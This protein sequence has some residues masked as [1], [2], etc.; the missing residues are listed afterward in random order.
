MITVARHNTFIFH[1]EIPANA[2]VY[3]ENGIV[4]YCT[5]FRHKRTLPLCVMVYDESLQKFTRRISRNK[6]F[7]DILWT[8][9]R[10]F[11][12]KHKHTVDPSYLKHERKHKKSGGGQRDHVHAITDYECAK[13]PLHDFRRVYY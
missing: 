11:A 5:D 7:N 13:N 3:A 1:Q 10:K 9:Y 8:E 4:L 2:I 12:R 6:Q